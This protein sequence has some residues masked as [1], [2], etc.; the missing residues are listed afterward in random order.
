MHTSF[1]TYF[2]SAFA[3]ALTS[4]S[5]CSNEISQSIASPSG[6]LKAVIFTRNC[7]AT[8]GFNT[9]ISIVPT[10][11][12]LPDDGGN[13]FIAANAFPVTLRWQSNTALDIISQPP[14]HIFK[15]QPTIIGVSIRYL[16]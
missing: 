11:N 8:T 2:L 13:A 3:I 14:G 12:E 6:E 4:C 7:G 9:Q 15:Q 10:R 1:A 5:N 16:R